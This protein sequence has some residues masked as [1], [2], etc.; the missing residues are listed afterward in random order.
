[1]GYNVWNLIIF[2]V[3][4]CHKGD[5]CCSASCSLAA[6]CCFWTEGA[7]ASSFPAAAH[8]ADC[9]IGTVNGSACSSSTV[10]VAVTRTG[11]IS[12]DGTG[13]E[14]SG[15][16]R[17]KERSKGGRKRRVRTSKC[18]YCCMNIMNMSSVYVALL[19]VHLTGIGVLLRLLDSLS[20]TFCI[21]TEHWTFRNEVCK[22]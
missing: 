13:T 20:W 17:G 16:P 10:P 4:I 22:N 8:I 1:M 11:C 3:V 7:E 9:P 19:H 14:P 6:R 15:L 5:S 21:V 12:T 18:L 2:V